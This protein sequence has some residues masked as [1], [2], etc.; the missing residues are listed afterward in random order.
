MD[1]EE[2]RDNILEVSIGYTGSIGT[3]LWSLIREDCD[4]VGPGYGMVVLDWLTM[5]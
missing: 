4:K 3:S 5:V 1:R 2:V